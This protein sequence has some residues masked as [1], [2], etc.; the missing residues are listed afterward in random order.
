MATHDADVIFAGGPVRTMVPAADRDRS[1]VGELR[2]RGTQVIEL[3]GRCLLPAFCDAHVHPFIGALERMT[4]DLSTAGSARRAVARVAEYAAAHPDVRWITGGGWAME[5]FPGGTPDRRPLDRVVPDRPAYLLNRDHHSAWVNSRALELAGITRD[6][7]DPADGR[8]EREADGTPGGTLHEGATRLVERL[9]PDPSGDDYATALRQAEDY[10]FSLGVTAWQDAIIGDYA[11]L[12]NPLDTYLDAARSGTLR[13]R[14]TGA[15][16]WDRDRGEEQIED[17][18]ARR[19][20]ASAARFRATTV[21]IMQDGVPESFTAAM[22]APYTDRCGHAHGSGFSYVPADR[23]AR[24]VPRLDAAGFQ[25]H[26]HAIGD[27]AVGECLDA[28]AAARAANGPADR[29]HHIAHLQFVRPADV[30]R[31]TELDVV[32]NCQALWAMHDRQ[33]D[34]LCIPYVGAERAGWQYPFGALA[35][36]G[37]RLAAGSDWPVSTPDPL[38]AIHVAV[39]RTAPPRSAY[40]DYPPAHEPFLP[41]QRLTIDQAFAMYTAGSAYV[42]HSDTETGTIAR[43][44]AADLVVLDRDPWA[45]PPEDIGATAV[46]LTMSGGTVVHARQ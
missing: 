39:N 18:L 40:A 30:P 37:A 21:K 23:L 38:R 2:G 46:D 4:C 22:S 1:A 35:R 17:L 20:R 14:V 15:L 33:M 41:E 25:V 36:Q 27:R 16:W 31:F 24:I 11:N 7:P 34:E 28:V 42:N 44:K 43:G 12:R 5:H 26:F 9:V 6:T 8:I 29:R 3:A 45:G 32:A 13:A 10:L 19:A